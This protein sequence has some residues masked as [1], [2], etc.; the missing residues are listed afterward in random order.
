MIKIIGGDHMDFI[1]PKCEH[2]LKLIN[3]IRGSGAYIALSCSN[4]GYYKVLV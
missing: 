4:C 1:C 2:E 3:E